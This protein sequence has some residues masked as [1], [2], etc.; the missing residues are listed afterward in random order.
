MQ[1]YRVVINN[2]D[3]LAGKREPLKKILEDIEP[4]T[5]E[6]VSSRLDSIGR[7]HGLA[8][9]PYVK[10]NDPQRRVTVQV[11]GRVPTVVGYLQEK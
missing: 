9:S 4:G 5:L 1:K 11:D 2:G 6:E 3:F 10:R 8:M 7:I